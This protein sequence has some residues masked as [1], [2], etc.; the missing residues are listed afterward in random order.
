MPTVQKVK[1]DA[2]DYIQWA[3][4]F[5]DPKED[6]EIFATLPGWR[7]REALYVREQ[8]ALGRVPSLEEIRHML[9]GDP[10]LKLH[11]TLPY[12][13]SLPCLRRRIAI[14]PPDAT[15]LKELRGQVSTDTLLEHCTMNGEG[16]RLLTVKP[17]HGLY[18]YIWAMTLVHRKIVEALPLPYFWELEEGIHQ[19]TGKVVSTR[20]EE[21]SHL[22]KWLDTQVSTLNSAVA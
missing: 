17:A 20:G 1:R 21:A 3:G 8:R 9:E 4:F 5:V 10:G 13:L 15:V 14:S 12:G 11:V 16:K 6:A 19:M 2:R 18:A 7:Q 22:L